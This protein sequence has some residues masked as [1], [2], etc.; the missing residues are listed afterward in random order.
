MHVFKNYFLD[1][2]GP[3]DERENKLT[4]YMHGI[5]QF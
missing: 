2:G 5:G 3:P 1:D 4:V